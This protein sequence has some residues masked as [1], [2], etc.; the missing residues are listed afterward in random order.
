MSGEDR[1]QHGRDHGRRAREPELPTKPVRGEGGRRKAEHEEHRA[2][3]GR[4]VGEQVKHLDGGEVEDVSSREPRLV[5]AEGRADALVGR[6]PVSVEDGLDL[7][8]DR[9]GV[10]VEREGNSR[11]P[12]PQPQRLG[13][14]DQRQDQAEDRA[15]G[16]VQAQARPWRGHHRSMAK[17][18]ATGPSRHAGP[19]KGTT[20][21]VANGSPIRCRP[22]QPR[23][24]PR[25]SSLHCWRTWASQ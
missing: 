3:G 12:V 18:W 7:Q 4:R 24:G 8:Q 6:I 5:E 1:E 11:T 20:P 17:G 14:G 2:G 23:V 22:C 13:G 9:G 15:G 16:A 10:P 25:P 19:T 21:G